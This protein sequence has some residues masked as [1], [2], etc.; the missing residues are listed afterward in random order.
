MLALFQEKMERMRNNDPKK[1]PALDVVPVIGSSFC[2]YMWIKT[3]YYTV[4]ADGSLHYIQPQALDFHTTCCRGG[5][6]EL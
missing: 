3:L 5:R 4:W 2:S 6:A 1:S